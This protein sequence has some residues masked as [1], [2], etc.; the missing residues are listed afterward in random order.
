M[1]MLKCMNQKIAHRGPNA[2]CHESIN[3][4]IY[5][6]HLRLSI[7]DLSERSNQPM[8][9]NGCTITYNGEIYNYREIKRELEALGSSFQTESDTEVLIEAYLRW[10]VSAF[11]K[12]NGMWAF[13]LYDHHQN[14]V[15]VSRDR[16]GKKPLYYTLAQGVYYFSSELK[17]FS[18]VREFA[19]NREMAFTF[20]AYGWQEQNHETMVSE[21]FHFPKGCYG[22]LKPGTKEELQ[23]YKYYD[24]TGIEKL[25][26]DDISF[27]DAKNQLRSLVFDSVNLR[28][29]AD[30]DVA[31]ALSGG[32]D[33][34]IITAVAA[35]LKEDTPT[36]NTRL[37]TFSSVFTAK[38]MDAYNEKR[39]IDAVLQKIPALKPHFITPDVNSFIEELDQ[40]LY[41]QDEPF[42]SAGMYAQKAVFKLIHENGVKVSLDGQGVD[43]AIGGYTSYNSIYLHELRRKN[44]ALLLK[45]IAGFAFHYPDL[46]FDLATQ[47]LR[48]PGSAQSI[49]G[50]KFSAG[51]ENYRVPVI[52][53]Y[54]ENCKF[55]IDKLFLPALLHHQDRNSMAYGV[56]S[57]S[58]FLDF[59]IVEFF[60]SMPTAY[61]IHNGK[62]KYILRET[63]KDLLP[64]AV[65]NRYGK[66][67]FPAPLGV[68]MKG[69]HDVFS[70]MLKTAQESGVANTNVIS[71]FDSQKK[72]GYKD[73]LRFIRI[74]YLD[75]WMRI[76]SVR[77]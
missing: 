54:V 65:Y 74:I 41:L 47:K 37:K 52:S 68:W 73:Y 13:V 32:I 33:S 22:I 17:S 28:L 55:Q 14:E 77:N 3:Q 7:I 20:L 59:R 67:G 69:N 76:Y 58:P 15:I 34:S 45:E 4:H 44:K 57:R 27:E 50:Q 48:K 9:K 11:A 25:S 75:R 66:L 71:A 49:I 24:I 29:R 8:H 46:F 16:F 42:F 10:G 5:F 30:V 36:Q 40:L 35:K 51:F 38:G 19:L 2:S 18:E 39:F 72:N 60:L 31:F 53:G 70:N 23:V 1:E 12:F 21:V 62:R 56:E 43:E 6:G 63:F 64:G 26:V 61:K